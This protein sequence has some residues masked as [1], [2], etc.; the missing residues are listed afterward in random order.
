MTYRLYRVPQRTVIPHPTV[1]SLVRSPQSTEVL[2]GTSRAGA[3]DVALY[4]TA[5]VDAVTGDE[6]PRRR[7]P[8]IVTTGAGSGTAATLSGRW[9]CT[10]MPSR[11]CHRRA[12]WVEDGASAGSA[13]AS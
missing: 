6:Q 9:A 5:S 12:A 1:G 3:D 11:L 7:G 4:T 8:F 10:V 2:F 13:T